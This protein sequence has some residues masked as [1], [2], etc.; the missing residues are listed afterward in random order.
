MPVRVTRPPV[1]EAQM[2]AET[3]E[4]RAAFQQRRARDQ[5]LLFAIAL[6]T[7]ALG[8]LAMLAIGGAFGG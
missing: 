7:A 5:R 6:L 2:R 1:D 3:A 8:G 4:R